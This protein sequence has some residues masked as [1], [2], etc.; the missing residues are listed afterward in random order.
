MRYLMPLL[1]GLLFSCGVAKEEIAKKQP[2]PPLIKDYNDQ[3]VPDHILELSDSASTAPEMKEEDLEGNLFGK[4]YQDR[5]TFYIINN[6]QNTICDVRVN[7][8]TMYY[9]DGELCKTKYLLEKD[10]T[11]DLINQYGKFKI[12]GFDVKT[13]YL[14][15]HEPIVIRKGKR[16]ELN[17]KFTNY[18]LTWILADKRLELKVDKDDQEEPY[19]FVEQLPNYDKI[20]KEVER[21]AL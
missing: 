9:L 19:K 6:P 5:A 14:L 12:Q 3:K 1:L 21:T 15:Q 17:R 4:F 8:L 18:K 13:R 20:R 2:A 7:T 10:V 16:W 11:N